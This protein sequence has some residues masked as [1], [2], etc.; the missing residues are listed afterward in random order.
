MTNIKNSFS[1]N[2]NNQ[3]YTNNAVLKR[4]RVGLI[5]GLTPQMLL[6][7]RSKL[8]SPFKNNIVNLPNEKNDKNG[9]DNFDDDN[10]LL[11]IFY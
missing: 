6:E 4:D 9:E 3:N 10:E 2:V 1:T 11:H 7:H 8:V 5:S